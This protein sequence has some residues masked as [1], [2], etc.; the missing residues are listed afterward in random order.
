MSLNIKDPE[1]HRMAQ[2]LARL[3]GQSM[4]R[5]VNDALRDRLKAIERAKGRA[6]LEELMAIARQ[7][8]AL[9]KGPYLDHGELL[10]DENGLPK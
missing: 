9:V 3:T 10:Y 6:S 2:E 4:T 8:A 5:V 7:S 1:T